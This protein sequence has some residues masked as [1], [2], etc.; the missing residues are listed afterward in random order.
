M[1]SVAKFALFDRGTK[2]IDGEVVHVY[3][4]GAV[5]ISSD[6]LVESSRWKKGEAYAQS[7]NAGALAKLIRD[8]TPMILGY[9]A[10]DIV[11]AIT[12]LNEIYPVMAGKEE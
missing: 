6:R 5:L 4:V 12:A 7:E 11:N 3:L 8:A 2:V 9:Q 1:K 10:G